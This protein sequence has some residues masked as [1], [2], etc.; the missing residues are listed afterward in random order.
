MTN[1]FSEAWRSLET[2]YSETILGSS[3]A[4]SKPPNAGTCVDLNP[5]VTLM[6]WIRCPPLSMCAE[7]M[8]HCLAQVF[9]SQ[10]ATS[11]HLWNSQPAG[12]RVIQSSQLNTEYI[13]YYVVFYV[14]RWLQWSLSIFGNG[15][16]HLF[17]CLFVALVA[18]F[19]CTAVCWFVFEL[20]T[21]MDL[22]TNVFC[23][24]RREGGPPHKAAPNLALLH[25]NWWVCILH[26]SN[27]TCLIYHH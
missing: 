5:L 6:T 7:P 21:W 23:T 4:R 11:T 3:Q 25:S 16:V 8:F 12:S 26:P 18:L 17:V 1:S 27:T 9:A 19:C 15:L 22:V 2:C 10:V 24:H 13:E 20:G 14:R